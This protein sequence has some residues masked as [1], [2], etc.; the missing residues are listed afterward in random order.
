MEN[1]K[2]YKS[3]AGSG[4]TYTL[5]KEYLKLALQSHAVNNFKRILAITFTNKAANEMKERILLALTD[6]SSGKEL[7]G[8]SAYLKAD[9]KKELLLNDQQIKKLS[10]DVLK[11]ILHNYA[12]FGIGTIDKFTYKI[13]RTFARD[14]NLPANFELEFNADLVLNKAI[15]LVLSKVG[16]DEKLT[17]LLIEFTTHN[18]G[19]ERKWQLERDILTIAK[20]ILKEDGL[21]SIQFLKQFN[22][23]D[24]QEKIDSYKT[25][26]SSFK[27]QIQSIGE[28]A[29]KLIEQQ[30]ISASSFGG[31]EKNSIAKYFY[32][33]SNFFEKNLSPTNSHIKTIEEDKWTSGKCPAG[34]KA[35]IES[36]KMEL[37]NF[38]NESQKI[39]ESSF[40]DYII[41]SNALRNLYAV[42][43][44]NEL[45]KE[46]EVIRKTDNIVHISEFNKRISA[47]ISSEPAPFIYERIGERY[48]HYLIDEF[49]DTSILQFHNLIP[50]FSN[51]LAEGHFNMLVGD[52]KQ[53]IY[54]FRGGEVEQFMQL[55]KIYKAD[56]NPVV[57]SNEPIFNSEFKEDYL[58]NNFRSK[59]EIVEFNNAFFDFIKSS[60]PQIEEIYFEQEQ[61]PNEKNTGGYVEFYFCE[62]AQNKKY[63]FEE[64]T[65]DEEQDDP[66]QVEKLLETIQSCIEDGYQYKDIAVLFRA[67]K[68]ANTVA[69]TLVDHSIPISSSESV[70]IGNSKSVNLVVNLMAYLVDSEITL[71]QK[72]IVEGFHTLGYYQ[73]D[74]HTVFTKYLKQKDAAVFSNHLILL[75]GELDIYQL[76]ER[77]IYE[78]A[79]ELFRNLSLFE[80]ADPYIQF[81]LD[82][83]FLFA[84][85]KNNDLAAFIEWWD[86]NKDAKA[87]II[88][89][90]I[91]AVNILTIHKSKGLEFPIVIFSHATAGLQ[92]MDGRW[93]KDE[94][95]DA[96]INKL[97]FLSMN[98]AI[99]KTKFAHI[100]QDEDKKR[101]IDFLNNLY[102]AMSRPKD[103]LYIIS[104]QPSKK[105]ESL[106]LPNVFGNYLNSIKI[107]EEG[108]KLYSFG[109][110][111]KVNS[112][113]DENENLKFI[114]FLSSDWRDKL[115][116]SL[117]AP[118]FWDIKLSQTARQYGN[119]LHFILAQISSIDDLD[120]VLNQMKNEGAINTV[121]LQ[122]YKMEIENLLSI[123]SI[124]KY[125]QKDLKVRTESDIITSN[126]ETYRPDRVVYFENEIT[127]ID[128]KTGQYQ[129]KHQEQLKNYMEIIQS[130]ESKKVN[131][132]LIYI[133]EGREVNV[134][135]I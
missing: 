57:A 8:T 56:E 128:F 102:V 83:V 90:G 108:K 100:Y 32:Y 25:T 49:Q 10:A 103:R 62:P 60:Y 88:P 2:V 72:N 48:K 17:D 55:P 16:L 84:Q 11:T 117:Q 110:L 95:A 29:I 113:I 73:E 26:I 89:D 15:D 106:S 80:K 75:L 96:K 74:L 118:N 125:F 4:K 77:P 85:K 69:Q 21:Q 58:K 104:K 94:D 81:F 37:T 82:E 34:E 40:S 99:E 20:E 129:E 121:Q 52:G 22:F 91:N 68:I 61:I 66:E 78:I 59:K 45:E 112:L 35:A 43:L 28:N 76:K 31:G 5:V 38:F 130:I 7:E 116:L 123:E 39:I 9:L 65:E 3:S 67:N 126:N 114:N 19:E 44:I 42:A 12:D 53:A 98:S 134:S 64:T 30:H 46:I 135:M 107:F 109:I 111:T 71:Y 97:D 1:F 122:E 23:D 86:Q 79:E 54:R 120:H 33:L 51:S 101:H 119:T 41:K 124:S 27:K 14:L 105:R 47:I 36:I 127:V 24:F 133:S 50:L 13:V 70:K 115:N 93:V 63:G 132:S 18:I 131:G 92:K 6:L 87:V